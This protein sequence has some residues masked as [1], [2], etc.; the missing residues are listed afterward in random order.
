MKFKQI[1]LIILCLHCFQS[2][3]FGFR[4]SNLG[5]FKSIATKAGS[6]IM[7]H[8]RNYRT[9]YCL[10]AVGI[11]GVIWHAYSMYTLKKKLY[12]SISEVNDR[13]ET[14][15]RTAN[16]NLSQ[17]VNTFNE[18][19]DQVKKTA[20]THA[21]KC[22][23]TTAQLSQQALL[24]QR[25]ID[26]TNNTIKKEIHAL[27]NTAPRPLVYPANPIEQNQ[28]KRTITTIATNLFQAWWN[29]GQ[30]STLETPTA[31]TTTQVTQ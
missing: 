24:L 20:D 15:I 11:I 9:G 23:E 7:T 1:L 2:Q 25:G 22:N 14:G 19:V 17:A 18:L 10:L 4:L 27:A 13:S 26:E 16:S 29:A 31:T 21:K 5:H 6:A 8:M 12:R 30:G 28:D 3:A